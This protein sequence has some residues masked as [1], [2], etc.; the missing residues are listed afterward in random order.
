MMTIKNAAF[1]TSVGLGGS[2]PQL[3]APQI[4]IVG[5]SNVGKSSFINSLCN[6]SKL[7]RTSQVPGKT[8]LINY[9]SINNGEF[10]LVDLPGYGFAKAPKSEQE[11]WGALMEEYLQS[12]KVTHILL[13]LDSRHEP[14]QDDRQMF[15]Y[16]QYYCIPHTLIGTKVDKI[17]KSKRAQAVSALPKQLRSLAPALGY[18]SE[19]RW[20]LEK[21]LLQLEQIVHDQALQKEI[22]PL[23]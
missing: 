20:G 4:A 16:I 21:V 6:N 7:A 12:G 18:S 2:H 19:D 11:K 15:A 9:F 13:L 8:R 14:T 22:A 1:L 23:P 3:D 10:Y 17:A 5:K